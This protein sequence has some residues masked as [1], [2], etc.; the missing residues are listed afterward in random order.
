MHNW[1]GRSKN[2]KI[3]LDHVNQI[4]ESNFNLELMRIKQDEVPIKTIKNY[5]DKLFPAHYANSNK[6]TPYGM[7]KGYGTFSGTKD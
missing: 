2:V 1:N 6:V 3:E 4:Q 5:G 7:K